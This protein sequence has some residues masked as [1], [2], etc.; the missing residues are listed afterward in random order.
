MA[1]A[2]RRSLLVK[3]HEKICAYAI[4]LVDESYPGLIPVCLPPYSLGLRLHTTHRTEYGNNTIQHTNGTLNFNRE[5]NVTWSIDNV[6]L[7]IFPG[8]V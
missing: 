7:M 4:H 2:F 3:L 5:V 6:N 1:L 8:T